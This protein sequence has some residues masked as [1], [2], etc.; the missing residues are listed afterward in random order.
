MNDSR[1]RLSRRSFAQLLG[2]GAALAAAPPLVKPLFAAE[3]VAPAPAKAA[4]EQAIRLSA[5]ENPYGPSPAAYKAMTE[6]FRLSYRYP[7]ASTD[8]AVGDIA[9]HHGIAPNQVLL[10]DGSA[11]ILKLSASAF[12]GNG[13]KLVM[14]DPTFEAIAIYAGTGTASIVKVP[15]TAGYAHDLDKMAAVA[16]ASLIYVCNPNNPTA[17]ITPKAAVRAF[18]DKVPAKTMVLVDEAYHHYVTSPDYESVIP[19][20]AS[21]PNLIVARTFSKIYAMAGLRLGYAVAQSPV[22]DKLA[23]HGTW[24][25][26]NVMAIAA[27]RASLADTKHVEEGRKR[28]SA[29]RAHVVAELEKLG[30][31]TIPSEANFIMTDTGRDVRL[32]IAKMRERG[33]EIG[34]LFPALPHH[35]RLTIGT[36][37]QMARFLR[38]FGSAMA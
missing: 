20:V 2:A 35:M 28:N 14:A 26:I 32:V 10:G 33:I 22:V 25:S 37:E 4:A 17:S 11:E 18:L 38:E 7:D 24:D 30:H 34:R 36:E 29:T 31:H 5:N 3:S 9:R 19:L 27:G 21:Y 15:L 1:I 8:E 6:A 12:A 13:K 16:D 23:M